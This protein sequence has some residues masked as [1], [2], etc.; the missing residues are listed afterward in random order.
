[1]AQSKEQLLELIPHK[2]K[3]IQKP[4]L[5]ETLKTYLY[6]NQKLKETADALFV[7]YKTVSYRLDKIK[8]ISNIRFDNPEEILQINIGLRI[9]QII[10]KRNLSISD[11]N[12]SHF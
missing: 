4:E 9:L 5:L 10:D 7:H 1:M 11:N 12:T 3:K 2:L 8:K 6:H